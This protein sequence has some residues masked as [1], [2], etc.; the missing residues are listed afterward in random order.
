MIPNSRSPGLHSL[1]VTLGGTSPPDIPVLGR[2]AHPPGGRKPV[3]PPGLR[4]G[5]DRDDRPG[6]GSPVPEG[7][8]RRADGDRGAAGKPRLAPQGHL[9]PSSAAFRLPG[10]R[11]DGG[12][13]P[14]RSAGGRPVLRGARARP[15]ERPAVGGLVRAG[16]GP[17]GHSHGAPRRLP[18][19]PRTARPRSDG[20][21]PKFATR[22]QDAR[23]GTRSPGRRRRT[24]G[25]R[26]R[27]RSNHHPAD[28]QGGERRPQPATGPDH[29]R[30]RSSAGLSLAT[31]VPEEPRPSITGRR[32]APAASRRSNGR[33]VSADTLAS[34]RPQ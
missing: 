13:C 2:L 6:T 32:Q 9:H 27:A 26:H 5:S 3:R 33:D 23:R 25:T 7:R 31:L 30:R 21:L 16:V 18:D 4:T 19:R 11:R 34:R 15:S 10:I 14:P 1:H 22:R 29:R 24:R 20:A 12:R 8:R 28:G 17:R